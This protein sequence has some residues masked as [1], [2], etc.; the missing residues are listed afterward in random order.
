[1]GTEKKKAELGGRRDRIQKLRNGDR[2]G[3]VEVFRGNGEGVKTNRSL[4][5]K[6]HLKS[7]T[8]RAKDERRDLSNRVSQ[9]L[10]LEIR[11]RAK[12]ERVAVNLI[13]TRTHPGRAQEY[14]KSERVGKGEV[15]E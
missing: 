9:R 6:R 5:R 15:K 3:V 13:R 8:A 12:K 1:L 2:P 7:R 10:H 4:G 14:V 11:R